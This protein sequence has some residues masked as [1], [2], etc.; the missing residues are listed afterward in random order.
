MMVESLT[1]NTSMCINNGCSHWSPCIKPHCH[2][3]RVTQAIPTWGPW[4]L[5]VLSWEYEC[6]G[7]KDIN[8]TVWLSLQLADPNQTP[9]SAICVCLGSALGQLRRTE[10]WPQANPQV[11][12]KLTPS[13][14][15]T[16]PE[17]TQKAD[18]KSKHGVWSNND[19]KKNPKPLT[20]QSTDHQISSWQLSRA[21]K[22]V[23]YIQYWT[24]YKSNHIYRIYINI[25]LLP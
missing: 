12:P 11:D 18:P 15:Q 13:R 19:N 25:C 22:M 21:G 7:L 5:D 4:R 23:V 16:N 17:Q 10:R 3:Y 14:P 8:V 6:E 2:G 1:Y 24:M 9:E 20:N